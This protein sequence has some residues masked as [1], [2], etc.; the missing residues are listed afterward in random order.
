MKFTKRADE[1]KGPSNYLKIKDGDS[2]S[3]VF[4]GEIYEF[5]VRWVNGKSEVVPPDTLG[6]KS[7]FKLNFI[8]S[9]NG[10]MVAK[11]WEFSHV[12][13]SLLAEVNEEYPLETTKVK[14]LRKGSGMETEYYI[15][16]LLKEPL[17]ASAI[18]SLA[19]I[20]LNILDK[21]P[22]AKAPVKNFAPGSDDFGPD[23]E[24]EET[25][26]VPF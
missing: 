15:L 22:A 24:F 2:I 5:C 12:V 21:A 26:E 19:A 6:A 23:P 7:R 3:G 20:E 9:E 13:Y 25:S 4:R 18:K 1:L 14:V 10:K 16:P 8:I 11:V 17:S